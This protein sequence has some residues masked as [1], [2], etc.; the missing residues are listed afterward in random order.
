[1]KLFIPYKFTSPKMLIAAIMLG[2]VLFPQNLWA[3]P[4][5]NTNQYRVYDNVLEVAQDMKPVYEYMKTSYDEIPIENWAGT[6]VTQALTEYTKMADKGDLY[7]LTALGYYNLKD[8]GFTLN[9]DKA[10]EYW[11]IAS[12]KGFIPA[13]AALGAYYYK[14]Y[15]YDTAL[16][17]ISMSANRNYPSSLRLL[18]S[19]YENGF[20]VE[21]NTKKATE[22]YNKAIQLGDTESIYMLGGLFFTEGDYDKAEKYYKLTADKGINLANHAL[23]VKF[24][25]I[26]GGIKPDQEAAYKYLAKY[27]EN[28]Y[29]EN[30][31]DLQKKKDLLPYWKKLGE[32]GDQNALENLS[33]YYDPDLSC[34]PNRELFEKYTLMGADKGSLYCQ[35]NAIDIYIYTKRYQNL[36]KGMQYLYNTGKYDEVA[37]YAVAALGAADYLDFISDRDNE[38]YF[39][40]AQPEID[41]STIT[42]VQAFAFLKSLENEESCQWYMNALGYCYA[43]AIGCQQDLSLADYYGYDKVYETDNEIITH[44]DMINMHTEWVE[45]YEIASKKNLDTDTPDI[46]TAYAYY[47]TAKYYINYNPSPVNNMTALEYLK[48]AANL[49][50]SYAFSDIAMMYMT[51]N[52]IEYNPAEA[53][54]YYRISS[55]VN[56]DDYSDNYSLYQAYIDGIGVNFDFDQAIYY[57]YLFYKQNAIGAYLEAREILV[58]TQYASY[59]DLQ[60]K[61]NSNDFYD[62]YGG[63]ADEDE[64]PFDWSTF[65]EYIRIN[66][67]ELSDYAFLPEWYEYTDVVTS[68]LSY[69]LTNDDAWTTYITH[70]DLLEQFS[71]DDDDAMTREDLIS[72]FKYEYETLFKDITDFSLF[73]ITE[74]FSYDEEAG[75]AAVPV[76]MTLYTDDDKVHNGY[77]YILMCKDIDGFYSILEFDYN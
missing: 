1:M 17:Y 28:R 45:K 12:D 63:S 8:T 31:K 34:E 51:G 77:F 10:I 44:D 21:T 60:Q 47:Q 18:A 25:S 58:N 13:T 27:Y 2:T 35:Q 61:A 55:L 71:E 75:V 70:D 59:L 50:L 53:V 46:S 4:D 9:E 30:K 32:K 3:K 76:G 36:L 23:A 40:S 39:I 5:K 68:F 11:Q 66:K 24:Y 15:D 52:Y 54:R 26:E 69:Y 64:Q 49:G 72:N 56:D 41:Y 6:S 7:A 48:K 33:K 57:L 65:G 14:K 67:D 22:Y 29:L 43:N 20:N 16:G 37:E 38:D 74:M 42:A 62:F 19:M 73:I